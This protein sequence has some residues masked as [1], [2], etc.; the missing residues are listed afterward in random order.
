M[1]V[2]PRAL[3]RTN[4]VVVVWRCFITVERVILLYS[5]LLLERGEQPTDGF[6]PALPT[7]PADRGQDGL[8]QYR[9][10]ATF[11]RDPR[12]FPVL[13]SFQNVQGQRYVAL[14]LEIEHADTDVVGPILKGIGEA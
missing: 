6:P 13:R 2:N 12:S 10:F 9:G 7:P 11:S 1:R 3:H 14:D 8:L 5:I 4:A